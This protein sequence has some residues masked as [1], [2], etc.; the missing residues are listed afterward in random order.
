[1]QSVLVPDDK[2]LRHYSLDQDVKDNTA[3]GESQVHGHCKMVEPIAIES[4][5]TGR[6]VNVSIAVDETTQSKA[7]QDLVEVNRVFPGNKLLDD[8]PLAAAECLQKFVLFD[9]YVIFNVLVIQLLLLNILFNLL[10][11]TY[12]WQGLQQFLS[13]RTVRNVVKNLFYISS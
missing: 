5:S 13:V 10:Q 6:W 1:M 7:T 4:K 9:V 11:S 2:R 12:Y 3:A 8:L